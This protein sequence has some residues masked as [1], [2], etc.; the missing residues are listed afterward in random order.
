MNG[1]EAVLLACMLVSATA[2][3]LARRRIPNVV[4]AATALLAVVAAFAG[5]DDAAPARLALGA[6]TGLLFALPL[7]ALRALGAGDAKLF[8]VVGMLVGPAL[9]PTVAACTAIAGGALAL[10]TLIA[11]AHGRRY[12]AQRTSRAFRNEPLR[13]AVASP[14]LPYAVA[15]TAGT[16][17]AVLH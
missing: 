14:R 3:D 16:V 12:A 2:T 13:E 17:L 15:I 8:A 4:P 11:S 5:A 10:T 1:I 7:F 6:A 9:I